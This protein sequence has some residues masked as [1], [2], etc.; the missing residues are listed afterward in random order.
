MVKACDGCGRPRDE[1]HD[2][3]CP[4][5]PTAVRQALIVL[6]REV[7]KEKRLAG[8]SDMRRIKM[9]LAIEQAERAL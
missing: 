6:L 1:E 4:K 5:H 7:K 2:G 8:E 9:R 3:D